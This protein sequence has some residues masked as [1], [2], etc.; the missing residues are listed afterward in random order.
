M[1]QANDRDLELAATRALRGAEEVKARLLVEMASGAPAIADLAYA[2]KV[3]VKEDYKI[4]E[5]VLHKRK[6]DQAYNVGKLRDIVGLRIVTLYRLDALN[7][8]PPLIRTIRSGGT[9]TGLFKANSFEEIIIYSTNPKGDAQNLST[10]L[11]EMFRREGLEKIARIDE[12]PRNYTSIHMVA[13]GR[14]KYRN[15]YHDVPVE[16]QIRTA[17]ED[18][19]GEIDHSLKYKRQQ[20]EG[21][22]DRVD[23]GLQTSLAHLNVLKTMI[24]GIA[25]YADQIKLQIT[26]LDG[27]LKSHLSR[28]AEDPTK[29]LAGLKIPDAIK[30]DIQRAVHY[31]RPALEAG[32]SADATQKVAILRTS[33][34]VLQ[35]ASEQVE[36][37]SDLP[38]RARRETD[39]VIKMQRALMLFEIGNT[40]EDGSAHLS[41]ALQIYAELE[42]RFRARVVIRYRLAKVLDAIGE[43]P[44]AIGKLREV[45]QALKGRRRFVEENHWICSAAP[46]VLGVLLWEA[47]DS[48]RVREAGQRS[49]SIERVALLREAF[50]V[51]QQAYDQEINERVAEKA[52]SERAKAANNLLYYALEFLETAKIAG[53]R[54]EGVNHDAVGFYLRELGGEVPETSLVD[55]RFLDTARRALTYLDQHERAGV[56]AS[57]LLAM[58]DDPKI[59]RNIDQRHHQEMVEA[60]HAALSRCKSSAGQ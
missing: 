38:T 27:R 14:G 40:L 26:E 55:W 43:R 37:L 47:A 59:A 15:S 10:K 30:E 25:Q 24:D 42:L 28:S 50:E 58:L 16:I 8:I 33:L 49:P 44:A 7:I 48:L 23:E 22:A 52:P 56:A 12:T 9:S 54:P 5:K 4:V 29:R 60:S 31:A 20:S 39:Y 13:W 45:L 2:I 53:E 32:P 17:F 46:R 1:A 34:E 11:M 41:R 19:W 6:E 18:V 36:A 57:R 21:N 51:T 3:R 35:A